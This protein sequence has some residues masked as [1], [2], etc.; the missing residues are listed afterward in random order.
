[1]VIN[2]K[3]IIF[4]LKGSKLT[5]EEKKFL[6]NNK[7]WGI[8]L[9][10]RNIKN[11]EQLKSLI[12]EIKDIF[13]DKK[14]PIL[15]DEEGGKVTRL[16]NI[17][18]LNFF[19]Q[20]FFASLYTKNKKVFFKT[21]EIYVNSLCEIFNKVGININTTPVLDLFNK[22]AHK[23]IG[24]RSYSSD[25]NTV[26]KLGKICIKLFNK[27]KIA[28]VTKHIPGHGK[29]KADSHYNT[30]IIKNSIKNLKQND[31]KAFKLCKSNFAMTGHAIY[32]SYDRFN[33]ATHSKVIINKVIRK[34]I[35][36]KGILISDDVSMKSLKLSL[37]Q[38]ALKALDS[39]CNLILHCNGKIGEMRKLAK[40]IPKIDT[41]TQKKTSQFYKFLG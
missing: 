18:N 13:N 12:H 33:T 11:I 36:F 30:P 39:G 28:T 37:K 15:I 20:R 4:G 41:F 3:A 40:V 1:M 38:N 22:K 25:T 29:S 27:N 34:Y 17:I 32:S 16:G 6:K 31:F 23:F 26:I 10:S 5:S 2:R 14:F 7:P 8:I 9:F 35:N 19:S 21:Y 24:S